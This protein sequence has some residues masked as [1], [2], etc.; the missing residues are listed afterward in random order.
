MKEIQKTLSELG[1]LEASKFFDLDVESLFYSYVSPPEWYGFPPALIPVMSDGSGP[2]Y[3]GL[4]HHWFG[5]RQDSFVEMSVSRDYNVTEIA[6]SELQFLTYLIARLIT[7]N[8]DVSDG[9]VLFSQQLGFDSIDDI[10]EVT[11]ESGDSLDG[12]LKLECFS[13]LPP[14][15]ASPEIYNGSFPTVNETDFSTTTP[16]EFVSLENREYLGAPWIDPGSDKPILFNKYLSNNELEKAWYTLNS[17][18]WGFADAAAAI[19]KLSDAS[20]DDN[21]SSF[22]A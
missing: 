16:F 14:L 20:D 12:L 18:G 4:W 11:L 15:E 1:Y 3:L 9:I 7:L 21:F 13:A 2:I 8:D 22:A 5:M 17:N 6:R 10:D 19:L